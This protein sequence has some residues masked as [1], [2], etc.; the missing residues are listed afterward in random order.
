MSVWIAVDTYDELRMIAAPTKAEMTRRIVLEWMIDTSREALLRHIGRPEDSWPPAEQ[1]E[2]MRKALAD[3]DN[4]VCLQLWKEA[5][6]I[7]WNYTDELNVTWL[8]FKTLPA[9]LTYTLPT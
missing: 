1:R 8:E 5:A 2:Q 4:Y 9:G 3:F 7:M 6:D